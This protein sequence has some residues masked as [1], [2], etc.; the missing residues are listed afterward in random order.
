[1]K[2]Y[3]A[4]IVTLLIIAINTIFMSSM[5]KAD[6]SVSSAN[7]S[8][9]KET[10]HHPLNKDNIIKAVEN[11][12]N[13]YPISYTVRQPEDLPRYDINDY[14]LHPAHIIK[15]KEQNYLEITLLHSSRWKNYTFYQHQ[16]K[17]KYQ[18]V[19]TNVDKDTII[20]RIPLLST[21]DKIEVKAH[22]TIP[23]VDNNVK[24]MSAIILKSSDDNT[25]TNQSSISNETPLPNKSNR[26]TEDSHTKADTQDNDSPT[27][28]SQN[29]DSVRNKQN[30]KDSTEPTIL[31][32]EINQKNK[33]LKDE[34][35]SAVKANS[36]HQLVKG[37]STNHSIP[38]NQNSSELHKPVS[39]NQTAIGKL[40]EQILQH[41]ISK[42][43]QPASLPLKPFSAHQ[44]ANQPSFDRNEDQK[45]PS[46][47]T[48]ANTPVSTMQSRL[49]TYVFL[50]ALILGAFIIIVIAQL[51][52]K[53][54][55]VK[56]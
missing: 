54:R 19:E 29:K 31:N 53:R 27:I 38:N 7:L 39:N 22:I 42:S 36:H 35:K 3:K 52:H 24:F 20:L 33:E 48:K 26:K 21:K 12:L 51:I 8:I 17:L 46:S 30:L 2:N 14:L 40:P 28:V 44:S 50:G 56:K 10:Q 6:D 47:Q 5:V 9:N 45:Q 11:N 4:F 16:E 32:T 1:M 43:H 23:N 18:V 13:K 41:N 55:G 37:E 34:D 25:D 15:I 49:K